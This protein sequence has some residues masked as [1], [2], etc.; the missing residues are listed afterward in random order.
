MDLIDAR[1]AANILGLSDFV[2][3]YALILFSVIFLNKFTTLLLLGL[4]LNL[5]M[6]VVLK[7]FFQQDR[8]SGAKNCEALPDCDDKHPTKGDGMPSGHS[9]TLGFLVSAL[10]LWLLTYGVKN[11]R[12]FSIL[13]LVI[14]KIAVMIARVYMGCHTVAQVAV[15][16]Y[17]GIVM[18]AVWFYLV[19]I[20]FPKPK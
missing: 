13:M 9:Q 10:G 19:L 2:L 11:T 6:N 20:H 4:I 16:S 8:P 12:Y 7:K 18:G 5:G 14:L 3:Y 17:I 1:Q 15:G